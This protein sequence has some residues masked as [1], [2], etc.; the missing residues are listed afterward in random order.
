M[1]WLKKTIASAVTEMDSHESV[2]PLGKVPFSQ[3]KVLHVSVLCQK[4]TALGKYITIQQL[5]LKKQFILKSM[6][7]LN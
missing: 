6:I 7:E 2:L 5:L 1:C 3:Q 4:F